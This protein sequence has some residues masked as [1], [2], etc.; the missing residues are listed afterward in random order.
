MK[1]T[2][3]RGRKL[4]PVDREALERAIEIARSDPEER[5]TIDRL[6]KEQG[7]YVAAHQAVYHCQRELIRPRLWQPMPYDIDPAQVEAIIARGP[8]GL[9]G[10]YQAARLLRRM[11]RAG[12]SRYEPDPIRAL[13]RA[14]ERAAAAQQ[15]SL[16]TPA[17]EP[18]V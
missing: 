2:N 12:L 4:S 1:R 5:E 13:E 10:E 17:S 15:S 16:V 6:M 8:D 14:K 18:G 9:A 3:H 7:W 11:L